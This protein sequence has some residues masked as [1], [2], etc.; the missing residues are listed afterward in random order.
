MPISIPN[1]TIGTII[2]M[3]MAESS[4]VQSSYRFSQT[5]Y[6]SHVLLLIDAH[7]KWM[8]V[9]SM[10]SIT[11]KASIEYLKNVFA[12]LALPEKLVSGNGPTFVSAEFK[13][14]LQRKGVKRITTSPY[15]L[16]SNG[17]AEWA[18]QT[19]K[20]SMRKMKDG[21]LRTKLA[22]FFFIYRTTPQRTTGISLGELLFG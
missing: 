18:V 15:H 1:A 17:L 6:G 7:S 22:Q 14:F 12:Q 5:I 11:A 20:S 4:L 2:T 21:S 10:A 19:F 3:A 9:Y 8:K 16:I 13:D